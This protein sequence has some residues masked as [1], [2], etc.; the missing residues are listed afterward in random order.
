MK[1]QSTCSVTTTL[2][3]LFVFA[4]LGEAKTLRARDAGHTRKSKTGNATFVSGE[5]QLLNLPDC[6][7]IQYP[8]WIGDGYCDRQ[9][10]YNTA[11][12]NWDGGDCCEQTCMSSDYDCS[13]PM[14][15]KDPTVSVSLAKAVFWNLFLHVCDLC[16]STNNPSYTP[17]SL[18]FTMIIVII[19]LERRIY[20][21]FHQ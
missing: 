16:R 19:I 10:G 6:Q 1:I 8:G 3:S 17:V 21:Y 20:D 15:C 12:C 9:G 11:E 13:V 14:D 5:R 4:A 7:Q 18:S 2:T